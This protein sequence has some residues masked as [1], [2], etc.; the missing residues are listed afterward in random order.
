MGSE[1]GSQEVGTGRR[2]LRTIK[3][4]SQGQRDP[5]SLGWCHLSFSLIHSVLKVSG[6]DLL[7]LLVAQQG[8]DGGGGG[9]LGLCRARGPWKA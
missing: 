8:W 3:G 4:D 1:S 9:M 7:W 5:S 2:W 6:L